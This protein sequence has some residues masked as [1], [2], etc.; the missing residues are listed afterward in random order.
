MDTTSITSELRLARFSVAMAFLLHAA[1]FA[2][3]T[4][5]IPAIKEGSHHG[6]DDS[7]SRWAAWPSGC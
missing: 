3:W 5:R 2:T 4:P 6:N 1:V 7:A